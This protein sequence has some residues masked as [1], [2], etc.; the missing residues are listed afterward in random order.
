MPEE[1]EEGRYRL[2]IQ[3]S[4]IGILE[5]FINGTLLNIVTFFRLYLGEFIV[6]EYST[7]F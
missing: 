2:G 5:I 1:I 4:F 7:T 6:I 3:S